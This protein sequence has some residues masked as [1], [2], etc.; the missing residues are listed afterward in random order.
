MHE[1]S[2][3]TGVVEILTEEAARHQVSCIQVVQLRVGA[4]RAVVPELLRTG[5]EFAGRGTA[6]EGA[7]LEIELVPGRARCP[8]CGVEFAIS[9]L[10]FLCPQCERVG[11]EILC[12]QELQIVEFEGE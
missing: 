11:G 5:M 8:D 6:A 2:L 4:L 1:L 10:L 7:R 9:E 3:A 12:G